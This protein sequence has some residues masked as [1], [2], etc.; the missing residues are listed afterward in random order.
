M[1]IYHNV[2]YNYLRPSQSTLL[3]Q[4]T[5]IDLE[6][7]SVN[8]PYKIFFD[9]QLSKK[10]QSAI[11]ALQYTL[12]VKKRI[13]TSDKIPIGDYL[14]Y[15]YMTNY[16]INQ[17]AK[18]IYRNQ[19]WLESLRD[20]RMN[21]LTADLLLN[22]LV[23]I[24][25]FDKDNYPIMLIKFDKD[26]KL[27]SEIIDAYI[28]AITGVLLVIK[29]YMLLP[30]Y[31]E[32]FS[33]IIDQ[34]GLSSLQMSLKLWYKIMDIQ[35]INF[36][37]MILNVF[38]YNPGNQFQTVFVTSNLLHGVKLN[39]IIVNKGEEKL[40]LKY[41]KPVYLEKCYGGELGQRDEYGNFWPPERFT[42]DFLG[43]EAIVSKG[44]SVFY[45]VSKK[46]DEKIFQ[47]D[48]QDFYSNISFIKS[49]QYEGAKTVQQKTQFI[50]QDISYSVSQQPSNFETPKKESQFS[51][52]LKRTFCCN[53][54][55]KGESLL[56]SDQVQ[57]LEHLS[58]TKSKKSSGFYYK[59]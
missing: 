50:A 9:V 14:R 17:S 12:L 54:D 27:S 4:K 34:D 48:R 46:S 2:N 24:N 58:F 10:D 15:L 32:K 26:K 31:Y 52:W 30:Y 43:V 25:G 51:T 39:K 35:Q 11:E 44:L 22:G 13:S 38:I 53:R 59:K 6:I 37:G 29:K 16:S 49:T 55:K 45:A 40:F 42:N 56:Q 57:E 18:Q 1:E 20:F 47:V 36:L 5:H 28:N 7:S 41:I 33:V 3:F 23:Y 8:N 19:E 21:N